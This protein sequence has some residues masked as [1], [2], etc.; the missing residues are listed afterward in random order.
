MLILVPNIFPTNKLTDRDVSQIALGPSRRETEIS[1][2]GPHGHEE[3][4]LTKNKENQ[5]LEVRGSVGLVSFMIPQWQCHLQLRKL[6]TKQ[7]RA[8]KMMRRISFGIPHVAGK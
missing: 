3:I 6:N 4:T 2:N 7:F 1:T 5:S 8:F